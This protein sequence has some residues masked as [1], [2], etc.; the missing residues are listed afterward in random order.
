VTAA[1]L[2]VFASLVWLFTAIGMRGYRAQ[3]LTGVLPAVFKEFAELL[4]IV[5][6]LIINTLSFARL[7][8]FALAHAGLSVAVMAL[9][10]MPGSML[11]KIVVF[12]IGNV[13]VIALEGLVVSIQTTRL[14]M[15]EFFRRFLVGEGRPFRPL[16]LPNDTRFAS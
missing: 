1:L 14:V 3:G 13:I 16:S 15:F 7:G 8:A 2:V 4:E 6:Q 10:E 5:F 11:G 12:I 9:T